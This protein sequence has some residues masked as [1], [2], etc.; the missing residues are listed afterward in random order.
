MPG[1]IR[2][3]WGG[4]AESESEWMVLGIKEFVLCSSVCVPWTSPPS[5]TCMG[6]DQLTLSWAKPISFTS[7]GISVSSQPDACEEEEEE[8]EHVSRVKR[9]TL[10]HSA[11]PNN[12]A[13]PEKSVQPG[14]EWCWV[15]LALRTYWGGGSVF[16]LSFVSVLNLPPRHCSCGW[17]G[18]HAAANFQHLKEHH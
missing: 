18:R 9:G 3:G 2:W 17:M 13:N 15:D 11:I 5:L 12:R 1:D 14:N 8:E 7:S 16:T 4:E 6:G 10:F